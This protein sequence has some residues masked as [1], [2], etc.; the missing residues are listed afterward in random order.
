MFGFSMYTYSNTSTPQLIKC[1]T[2]NEGQEPQPF[3]Y[4]YCCV[5]IRGA[6][7]W[8]RNISCSEATP[9]THCSEKQLP[10]HCQ[11]STA[12]DKQPTSNS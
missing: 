4:A 3:G 8:S 7:F 12:C 2:C 5:D 10:P 1:V 9:S 11:F 6:T